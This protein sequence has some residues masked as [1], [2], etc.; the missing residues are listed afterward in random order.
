[1]RI[2]VILCLALLVF[3]CATLDDISRQASTE[4]V[5]EAILVC[6][7]VLGF[8]IAGGIIW[9]YIMPDIDLYS[10]EVQ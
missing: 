9:D 1:M 10:L 3:S 7:G 5:F 4:D 2:V 8:G 6:A